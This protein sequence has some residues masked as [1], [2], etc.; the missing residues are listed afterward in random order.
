MPDAGGDHD[1]DCVVF[2]VH[3]SEKAVGTFGAIGRIVWRPP[4]VT[5]A[6]DFIVAGVD[7]KVTLA[8]TKV[9]TP[10]VF[11]IVAVAAI[12]AVIN[13]YPVVPAVII[14]DV[15]PENVF[16]PAAAGATI[17]LKVASPASRILST[18]YLAFKLVIFV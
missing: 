11:P 4:I 6:R 3:I 14:W 13:I 16:P 9:L 17:V 5:V 10:I 2:D 8:L 15:N 18:E 1:K 12:S 7:K